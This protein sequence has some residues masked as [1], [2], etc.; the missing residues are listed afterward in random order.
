MCHRKWD[1]SACV[2]GMTMAANLLEEPR[3]VRT[4]REMLEKVSTLKSGVLMFSL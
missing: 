1:C 3:I 4:T 2:S